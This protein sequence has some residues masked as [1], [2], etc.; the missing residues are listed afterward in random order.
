MATTTYE[1]RIPSKL[2]RHHFA[3]VL[4]IC[5]GV[6]WK[7]SAQLYFCTDD[8]DEMKS[9]HEQTINAMKAAGRRVKDSAWRLIG[10]RINDKEGEKKPTLQEYID[11]QGLDGWSEEEVTEMYLDVYG[12]TADK[13]RRRARLRE[14]QVELV[15]KLEQVESVQPVASDALGDWIDE[16][17]AERL[18]D[19]GIKTLGELWQ[20]IMASKSWFSKASGIGEMKAKRIESQLA[21]LIPKDAA[22]EK[23]TFKKS[24]QEKVS[25]GR[26]KDDESPSPTVQKSKIWTTDQDAVD[27]WIS[28]YRRSESSVKSYRREST[29]FLE[30]TKKRLNGKR[31]CDV[32]EEECVAYKVFLEDIPQNWISRTTLSPGDDGWTPFR[33]KLSESSQKQSVAVLQGFF[34]WLV[35][36][37]FHREN[38]W[39]FVESRPQS[40][41]AV[42]TGK[43]QEFWTS[44]CKAQSSASQ[45]RM[46]FVAALLM[47][48]KIR[49]GE[50][51]QAVLGDFAEEDGQWVIQ[52]KNPGKRPRKCIVGVQVMHE[53]DLYLKSRGVVSI[54]VS[55]KSLP[56][57]ASTVTP[58]RFVSYQSLYGSTKVWMKRLGI[59]SMEFERLWI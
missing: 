4:A 11:E 7:S 25:E 29:R 55:D 17:T 31:L 19:I 39:K 22:E 12:G 16:K 5:E 14:R 41:K 50:A 30:W 40:E 8:A 52:I 43:M 28:A 13:G 3:H 23:E 6:D 27:A 44:I 1:K 20:E 59:K 21:S 26:Q 46:R 10:V 38:P 42:A 9:L 36:S 15:R 47:G 49:P 33:G 18:K 32:T 51:V 54:D 24:P 56:M 34:E 53:L 57:I 35:K 2:G 48:V 37:G 45:S 58:G